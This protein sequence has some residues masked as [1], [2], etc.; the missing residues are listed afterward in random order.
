M[1]IF[2]NSQKR[3]RERKKKIYRYTLINN[4]MEKEI[5]LHQIQILRDLLYKKKTKETNKRETVQL[6]YTFI[7]LKQQKTITQTHTM[8]FF[9]CFENEILR[10][11][12]TWFSFISRI[13]F[14]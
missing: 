8:R 14:I 11:R 4:S 2:I 12:W 7:F 5:D 9:F 10:T 13:G 3:E 6:V 1:K